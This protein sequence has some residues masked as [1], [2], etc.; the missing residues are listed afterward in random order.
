MIVEDH[1][2][3]IGEPGSVSIP[4]GAI[5]VDGRGRYLIPG[6]VDM[7]V[8]LFNNASRR[9]PND[10]TFPL[11]VANG[12]TAVRE[13]NCE[14][15]SLP[16]VKRWRKAAARG[17]LPAPRILAAGVAVRGHSPTEARRLEREA[18]TA[19]ADFI[20]V[21]SD[22][23]ATHWRAILEEARTLRLPV[24]GHIPA[25][26]SLLAAAKA[27]QRSNEH[28]TEAYEACSTKEKALLAERSRRD[29]QETVTF[30]DAQEE[31]VLETFD[32]NVCSDTAGALAK[33]G[34]VQVPTLVLPYLEAHGA[35]AGFRADPRWSQLRRDEQ[36]RWEKILEERLASEDKLA[37]RRWEVSR[38]VVRS[39]HTA[40]VRILAGTD[41]PMPL[42]YPGWSLHQELELLVEAGLS[43]ADALRAATLW[44]AEFLHLTETSGS[45]A[46]G[47]RADL[48]LLE[49]NPLR[50]IKNTQRIRA[51]VL[52]GRL[53]LRADLD[54]L[55]RTT[56]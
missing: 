30:P 51:V 20:K 13:M 54:N 8:H 17:E 22:V 25:E 18:Q 26:I 5:R 19:G 12:V 41:T 29:T 10:W 27:G 43:P 11:F 21:F 15:A 42:N 24:C 40:H 2:G 14:P 7:H 33:T 23:P 39:F 37:S 48:V 1:I 32:Q 52:D 55:L 45:I 9:P 44:P 3:T 34:Q 36:T 38:A 46:T 4:P 53:L 28:L 49:D 6:L 47:K 35:P 31:T 56:R 16:L 50:E